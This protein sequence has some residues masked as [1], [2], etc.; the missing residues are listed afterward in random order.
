[1]RITFVT[2]NLNMSGG[3]KVIAIYARL[4]TRRGHD[5]V[6]IAMPQV[7]I[8]LK[9][10]WRSLLQGK[11]GFRKKYDD[12][13]Q[14]HFDELDVPIDIRTLERWRPVTDMDVPDADVVLA[15]LWLTGPWVAALSPSKGA[16]AFFLQGYE[17]LPGEMNPRIDAAW[18]LPLRKIVISNWMIDL[19]RQRFG[20]KEVFHVPNSVDLDQFHAP[21]RGKQA[22]PTIGLLYSTSQIKGVAVSLAAIQILL[23]RFQN[24]RVVSFGGQPL[25][26]E[27]P[28]PD[29]AE[30]HF[31]PPQQSIRE[32]YAACDVWLC[33]SRQ[34][35][36][37][38]P[39]LEAMACRC[40]VVSTKVGGPMD[41]VEDSVNGFLV[42]VD[43][44]E[45][46]AARAAEILAA[47]EADWKRMSDAALATARGYS[48]D[49]A[50]DRF[51]AALRE[52]VDDAHKEAPHETQFRDR[53][54]VHA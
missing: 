6:I 33:G 49:D 41:I 10:R 34:E 51:E 54:K 14:S 25:S 35:G 28:M 44:V 32:I 23:S 37:H 8:P 39:P 53:M 20:D 22:V 17:A 12:S 45:G 29:C 46:L 43:D 7:K 2:P 42:E 48:W 52:I 18:R 31:H 38:L 5:V 3:I 27:L 30:F 16:K 40:P 9:E 26:A 19:A 13:G 24:L 21:S 4:L 47:N 50:T 15:T 11:G 1:M 36:F